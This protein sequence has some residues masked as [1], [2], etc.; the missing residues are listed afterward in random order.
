MEGKKHYQINLEKAENKVEQLMA[1]QDMNGSEDRGPIKSVKDEFTRI[2]SNVDALLCFVSLY[3]NQNSRYFKDQD[4]YERL[5]LILNY[6]ENIQREDGT[7]DL[8]TTN[9]Y[10]APD[11]GFR[12][13]SLVKTYRIAEKFGTNSDHNLIVDKLYGIIKKAGYGMAGGGFHTPN[14]RWVISAA[15]MMAY[16]ITEIKEFKDTADKYLAEGI[17]CNKKGGYTEKSSGIY[18]VVNNTAMIM[19]AR[20][21]GSDE[22]LNY[23][24]RNLVRMFHFM[25]PD[26]SIFTEKST[27]QD[28][29]KKVYPTKYYF[30]YFYMAYRKQNSHYAY[31]AEE[32][33]DN[34]YQEFSNCLAEFMLNP[35]LKDF[36]VK[37]EPVITNYEKQFQDAGLIR[38]RRNDVSVSLLEEDINFLHFQVGKLNCFARMCTSFFGRGQFRAQKISENSG[39]YRLSYLARGDYREPF[40]N[41]PPTAVWE[42]MDHSRRGIA[43]ELKLKMVV[44]IKEIKKGIKVKIKTEGCDRVPLKLEFNFSSPT[45]IK[46]D[47]FTLKGDSA[48]NILAKNGNIKVIKGT[49]IIKLGP[50]FGKHNYT[51]KMRG[52]VSESSKFT[53]YFTEFTNIERTLTLKKG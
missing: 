41:P 42:E 39:E 37:S 3:F 32:I 24:D 15:L 35:G 49:D 2:G 43:K 8:L 38:I 48:E 27:R 22:Y 40:D 4:I 10:S 9:F 36:T 18:N 19:L 12:I 14:H 46:G 16:N 45:L 31:L 30:N 6:I 11:T 47:G 13:H 52:S 44:T 33:V 23:V 17:D 53:V 25:E 51:S 26:G 34:Y 50:A 29:G 28:K 7:F 20:E 1:L 5:I 21:T